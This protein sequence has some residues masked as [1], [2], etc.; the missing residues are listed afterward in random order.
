MNI[1]HFQQNLS[2][3]NFLYILNIAE[4]E[5]KSQ[6]ELKNLLSY[7][8]RKTVLMKNLFDGNK[9]T[10]DDFENLDSEI[11]FYLLELGMDF[12]PNFKIVNLINLDDEFYPDFWIYKFN[13]KRKAI[14]IFEKYT[15]YKMQNLKNLISK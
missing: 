10:K 13:I 15:K 5:D 11:N 7:Y 1:E 14:E 12:G 4:N 2:V 9:S 8:L 6:N 3:D